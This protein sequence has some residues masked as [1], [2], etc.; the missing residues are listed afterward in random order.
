MD[1]INEAQER[2]EKR[3]IVGATGPGKVTEIESLL[4]Y[5]DRGHPGECV[6]VA[7]PNV[8]EGMTHLADITVTD[9]RE[10]TIQNKS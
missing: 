1:I 8:I 2:G 6:S 4:T 9:S 7:S 5:I 10:I 3:I